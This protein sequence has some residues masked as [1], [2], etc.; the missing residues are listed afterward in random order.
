MVMGSNIL[1]LI[2]CRFYRA[3]SLQLSAMFMN[4]SSVMRFWMLAL[5]LSYNTQEQIIFN[6]SG[7]KLRV[8]CA[9]SPT[10]K[11]SAPIQHPPITERWV[12]KQPFWSPP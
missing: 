5:C 3:N 10:S 7:Q 2:L 11:A 8:L 9:C 4:G 1:P 12:A 6:V